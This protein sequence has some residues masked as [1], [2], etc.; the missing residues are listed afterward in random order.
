MSLFK[1]LKSKLTG[2]PSQAELLEEVPQHFDRFIGPA[3]SVFHEIVSDQVHIDVHIIHAT[4]ARPYHVLYTTGM[5]M[6][7]MVGQ[8]QPGQSQ[9]AELFI[10]LPASLPVSQADFQNPA[11]YWPIDALKTMARLPHQMRFIMR[12]WLSVPF[13]DPPV[14]APGTNF[15][16]TMVVRPTFLPPTAQQV[17]L[18]AGPVI[19]LYALMPLT[20]TEMN[21]K[22]HQPSATALADLM[23]TQNRQLIDLC[24]FD[25][26]RQSLV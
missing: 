24:L 26:Q 9:L 17:R 23:R 22:A 16:G 7:A 8:P 10:H 19:Q 6:R 25:P 4:Q 12:E 5:S 21:F 13:Q 2:V 3:D 11:V 20:M 18:R 15:G 1:N 14:P